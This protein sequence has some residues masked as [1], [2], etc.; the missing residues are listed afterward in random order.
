M[1]LHCFCF[2]ANISP[3]FKLTGCHARW[4]KQIMLHISRCAVTRQTQWDNTHAFSSLQSWLISKSLFLTSSDSDDLFEK[5]KKCWRAR[6]YA[7]RKHF[8]QFFSEVNIKVTKGQQRSN[9]A[10][11]NMLSEVCHYLRNFQRQEVSEKARM[12]FEY[13]Q[14]KVAP[15]LLTRV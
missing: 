12:L 11:Q 13:H 10:K 9:L 15:G 4:P 3:Q 2:Q 5:G 6:Q 1:L 14:T 8:S 7:L